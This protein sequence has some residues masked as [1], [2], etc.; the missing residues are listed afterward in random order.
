MFENGHEKVGGREKGTPNKTTKLAKEKI[1]ELFD[2]RFSEMKD[3]V[4]K[5]G[6]GLS[7]ETLFRGIIS[8]IPK[9]IRLE[10]GETPIQIL[11]NDNVKK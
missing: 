7:T 6:K 3:V 10:G 1:L 9:D 4:D 5:D 8:L 11:L 2:T